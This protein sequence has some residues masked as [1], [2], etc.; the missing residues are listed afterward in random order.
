VTTPLEVTGVIVGAIGTLIMCVVFL[1]I[2]F[3]VLYFILG[4]ALAIGF[5]VVMVALV[6]GIYAMARSRARKTAR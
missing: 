6:G 4:P 5:A 2:V 1:V 3:G